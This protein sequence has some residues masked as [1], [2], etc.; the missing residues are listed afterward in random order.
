ML[1]VEPTNLRKQLPYPRIIEPELSGLLQVSENSTKE[2]RLSAKW[3]VIESGQL[4]R[5]WV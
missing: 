1:Q 2:P 3:I 5:M 4:K